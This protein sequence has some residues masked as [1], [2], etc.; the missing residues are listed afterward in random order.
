M[1]YN[2][3]VLTHH[4]WKYLFII[5]NGGITPRTSADLFNAG[6]YTFPTGISQENKYP[7]TKAVEKINIIYINIAIL[8][9]LRIIYFL[10]IL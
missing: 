7:I 8:P 5:V 1:N 6:F 9:V 4:I 2:N 3:Y 10:I